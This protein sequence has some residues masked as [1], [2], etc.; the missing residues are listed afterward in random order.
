M[1]SRLTR[2]AMAMAVAFVFTGQVE[3]AANHCARLAALSEAPV[4]A[5]PAMTPAME[6]APCHDQAAAEASSM[7][8]QK[9]MPD[10]SRCECVAV[11][12]AC[13]SPV[14]AE[15]SSRMEAYAWAQPEAVTFASFDPSPDLR[16]PRA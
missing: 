14:A 10:K 16:P 11:L 5:L 15:A 13:A 7:P 9:H 1:L 12:T 6:A 4:E 8:A 3:A 2:I